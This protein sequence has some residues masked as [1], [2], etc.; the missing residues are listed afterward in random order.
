MT[1]SATRLRNNASVIGI[2]CPPP[3]SRPSAP[4]LATVKT[5]P[6]RERPNAESAAGS[7]A[8][9]RQ[10]PFFLEAEQFLVGDGP[11]RMFAPA[12]ALFHGADPALATPLAHGKLG[13]AQP[14]GN[15]G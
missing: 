12:A 5:P 9:Q 8:A 3:S 15:L 10:Q 2:C 14:L 1:G 11:G 7:R 6:P 13:L 4:S